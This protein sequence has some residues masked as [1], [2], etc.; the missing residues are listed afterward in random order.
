M[1]KKIIKKVRTYIPLKIDNLICYYNYI[2]VEAQL[3]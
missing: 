1:F 2:F 3:K